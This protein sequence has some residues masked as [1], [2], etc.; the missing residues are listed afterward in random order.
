MY[1]LDTN[2]LRLYVEGDANVVLRVQ[3][4]LSMV[5][6]SSVVAEELVSGRLARIN[7]A[8]SANNSLSVAEAHEYF[9]KALEDLRL[10]PILT[11]SEAADAVFDTLPAKAKR[12]GTQDCRIAAQ[13]IAHG[14]TVVT[15][16]V[17]DF[18]AIGAPFADWSATSPS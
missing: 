11:Y 17:G 15:R 5:F 6:I 4:N 16:N 10:L 18:A 12:A 1:L 14:L 3:E 8:R 2:A 13:A 9:V 7:R